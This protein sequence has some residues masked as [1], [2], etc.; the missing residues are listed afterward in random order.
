MTDRT[1]RD[2]TAA[3]ALHSLR[4][5]RVSNRYPRTVAEAYDGDIK[6]AMRATDEEVAERVADWERA[7]GHPVRDWLAIG[8][9]E[10]GS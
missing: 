3:P 1:K 8:R 7:N 2:A 5:R 6:A 4:F 9:E 10:R